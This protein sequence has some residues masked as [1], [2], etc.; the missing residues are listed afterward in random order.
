[1]DLVLCM[2][3]R[4]GDIPNPP[5][6]Y[7]STSRRQQPA[8]RR[9]EN[10]EVFNLTQRRALPFPDV[11]AYRVLKAAT[12]RF[13]QL[14]C[15]VQIHHQSGPSSSRLRR[16][17]WGDPP[18]SD[19]T[20]LAEERLR[21][22]Q[23]LTSGDVVNQ[24]NRYTHNATLPYLELVRQNLS[25]IP[26]VDGTNTD[27]DLLTLCEGVIREKLSNPCFVELIWSYWHEE[28]MLVQTMKAIAWRF[29]NRRAPGEQDPLAL[30][31]ID[32]LRPLS[33]LL[34]GYLQDEQHRLSV[35][36]RAYEY[37]HHY[38][39]TLLGKAVPQVRGADTRS[40]FI[41]AFHNL[42]Y[43]CA[44][45]YKE[46]DDTTVVADG[47]PILN[48]LR[49]VHLLL[50]QG[51]HNQ[52]GDLPW[53]ARQEM[54]MEQWLLARP[55]FREYLPRRIM[56]D[57]PEAWMHSVETMKT[58]QGWSDTSILHFRDLGVFGERI[59]LS[60][61]FRDWTSEIHP[62]A[63]ANWARY[64][65]PEIQGYIHAYRA[66]T[67]VDLTDHV[68]VTLPAEL[69]RRR[70]SIVAQGT[71]TQRS[72]AGALPRRYPAPS[73]SPSPTTRALP[74]RARQPAVRQNQPEI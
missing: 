23:A 14:F 69:L 49:E 71:V 42:L 56:V 26:L 2:D 27:A 37:D 15:G 52:Y 70:L 50:T 5:L 9:D 47:F 29:Q 18:W 67:G 72:A 51:A 28:G 59:V 45:F 38:G 53:T 3:D 73:L 55:E 44:I 33:N 25:G 64:W 8:S 20:T 36:R 17:I 46:D 58:L 43:L 30:L 19:R 61:R 10:S 62:E 39:I 21:I 12:E 54:L 22:Y 16:G 11:D 34:W 35:P 13:M 4:G 1:M 41:E 66:V 63:A 68:D 31:E 57:Y 60:S 48:A 40:R 6:G 74:P 24:W 65:R 32:P 7:P